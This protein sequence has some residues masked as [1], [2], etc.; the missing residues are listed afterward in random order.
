MSA[1]EFTIPE[2]LNLATRLIAER[3]LPQARALLKT[4]LARAP[5]LPEAVQLMGVAAFQAGAFKPAL[6]WF[7]R[8]LRLTPAAAQTPALHRNRA[9][10]AQALGRR[11]EA[12]A[13]F[14][15]ALALDETYASAW[16]DLGDALIETADF[17]A[18]EA[19]YAR[20]TELTPDAAAAWCG[21][22]VA[23]FR[24]G[25]HAAAAVALARALLLSPDLV[26]ALINRGSVAFA[27]GD[28]AAA[29][30][31]FERAVLLSPDAHDAHYNLGG[32]HYR[33]GRTAAA[34]GS[35]RR[36]LTLK[37]DFT[38]T[39][40]NLALALRDVG[41]LDE[42]I[43]HQREHVYLV[44]ESAR[45]QVNLGQSLLDR[46]ER[47][48]AA[49]CLRR[50]LELEPQDASAR[51]FLDVVEGRAS[52]AAPAGYVRELF[53]AYAERFDAH[54]VAALEYRTPELLARALDECLGANAT[55][56]NILD[57]GCGTGLMGV[58]L[59]A[60]ARQLIGVDLSAGMLAKALALGIYE[61]FIEADLLTACAAEKAQSFDLIVA[62]DVFV[63]VGDLTPIFAAVR[64]LLRP[65]GWFAF[66][67]EAAPND[68]DEVLLGATGRY[69]HAWRHV[70]RLAHAHGF[71]ARP[72]QCVAIRKERN[73]AVQGMLVL[74]QLSAEKPVDGKN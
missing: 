51:H 39:L 47:E 46:G 73:V 44:P 55:G 27:Q 2:A 57:L 62:A 41:A 65:D 15:A 68:G 45:A 12:I 3:D 1:T 71:S 61:R 58:P 49:I 38:D 69:A 70:E 66:S 54:L 26:P 40:N 35:Y 52:A 21:S 25:Q 24:L 11:D 22:G 32:V 67:I 43:V 50:A 30:T 14:R 19:A 29:Q 5:D 17:T 6:D 31:L 8:A 63:Y 23:Q 20:A 56:L 74:L 18:A 37:P 4:I 13:G 33:C 48:A 60:R 10:A 72:P 28:L 59:K 53:D 9:L 36:A 64:R 16:L 7:E 34:I 42:A